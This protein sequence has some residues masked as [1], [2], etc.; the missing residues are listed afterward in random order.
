MGGQFLYGALV[1]FN[2]FVESSLFTMEN[3]VSNFQTALGFKAQDFLSD[4]IYNPVGPFSAKDHN[5]L[6]YSWIVF[7]EYELFWEII[8]CV[9]TYTT[10]FC[11]YM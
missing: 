2:D 10:Q 1:E 6:F 7:V 9:F 11:Y 5:V 4:F 8:I 3:F